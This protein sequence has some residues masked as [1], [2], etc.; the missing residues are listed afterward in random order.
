MFMIISYLLQP[1]HL[2]EPTEVIIAAESFVCLGI[3]QV[4]EVLLIF[5]IFC[6]C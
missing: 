3:V 5:T 1:V 2:S 6:I 4:L